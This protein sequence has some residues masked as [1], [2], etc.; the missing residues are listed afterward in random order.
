VRDDVRGAGDAA[1]HRGSEERASGPSVREEL[2]EG[3]DPD[4]GGDDG[5]QGNAVSPNDR[6]SAFP[7]VAS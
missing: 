3:A 5:R 2:I 6:R 7:S 4:S 1:D